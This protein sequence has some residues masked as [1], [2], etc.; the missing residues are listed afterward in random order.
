[1]QISSLLMVETKL[2][3]PAIPHSFRVKELI[4]E[5]IAKEKY[6]IYTKCTGYFLDKFREKHGERRYKVRALWFGSRGTIPQT[7]YEFL[8]CL[9]ADTSQLPLLAEEI[10]VDSL[11]ILSHHIFN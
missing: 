4:R 9:G 5:A 3:L 8:S 10:L 11:G 2:S 7:T 6:D 1:M